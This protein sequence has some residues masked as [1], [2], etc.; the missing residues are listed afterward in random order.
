[1]PA[2]PRS[3]SRQVTAIGRV[4]LLAVAWLVLSA[5]ASAPTPQARS[6]PSPPQS[7]PTFTFQASAS[8]LA[9]C[10]SGTLPATE[11]ISPFGFKMVNATTGWALGQCGGKDRPMPGGSSVQCMWPQVETMGVLRTTDGGSHWQDVSPPSVPNRS[12]PHEEFF[13]DATHAWVVEVARSADACVDHLVVFRTSDGGK[14]WEQGSPIP[15]KTGQPDDEIFNLCYCSL[16]SFGDAQHGW[17]LVASPPPPM[18]PGN[19]NTPASLYATADGGLHWTFLAN[20]PGLAQL[21][22]APGCQPSFY[23][24]GGMTFDSPATGRLFISC[25]A[26]TVLV[27]NDAGRSW[28]P[29]PLPGCVCPVNDFAF[30]D[31][32]HGVATGQQSNLMLATSDGGVSWAR[33][34]VPRGTDY[35]SFTDPSQGWVLNIAQLA[36]TYDVVLYRTADGGQTWT[37]A[38]RPGFSVTTS[39]SPISQL[40]FVD[41]STGFALATVPD[42]TTTPRDAG[43]K[44]E[45]V[46]LLV[47]TSDGGQTWTVLQ[48]Q[49]APWA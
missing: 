14:N 9:P 42:S 16:L 22:T 26:Q 36:T 34:P 8:G 48:A 41:A 24:M 13:L 47:K 25:P 31:A 23:G 5:C 17:L 43:G 40:Q 1:M 10:P 3:R 18:P 45:P 32:D 30:F 7:R 49:L 12:W 19:M 21:N 2:P 20:S 29:R 27:T 37:P 46:S 33:H 11:S 44:A 35:F 39:F 38:G 4:G 6:S 15:Y 28:V